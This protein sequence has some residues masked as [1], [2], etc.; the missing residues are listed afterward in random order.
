MK[1]FFDEDGWQLVMF[2]TKTGI[3]NEQPLTINLDARTISVPSAVATCA[4]VQKDQLAEML[5]FEVDRFFDIMD[6][7]NTEIF[8]QWKTTDREGDTKIAIIDF[9]TRAGKLLFAWPLTDDITSASGAVKFSARFLVK[10]NAGAIIYSLNTQEATLNI[11]PALAANLNS[12]KIDPVNAGMFEHIVFNSQNAAAGKSAPH[13]PHFNDLDGNIALLST[14]EDGD[15][16][17]VPLNKVDSKLVA[18]LVN[19]TVSFCARAYTTDLGDIRYK[20]YYVHEDAEGVEIATPYSMDD[21]NNIRVQELPVL[22]PAARLEVEGKTPNSNFRYYKMVKDPNSELMVPAPCTASDFPIAEGVKLY[23]MYSVFT[24]PQQDADPL[25]DDTVVGK[26]YVA[27]INYKN[28]LST[29]DTPVRSHECILPGPSDIQIES[30]LGTSKIVDKVETVVDEETG[31]IR[32]DVADDEAFT[33]VLS[34]NI[35]NADIVYNWMVKTAID[36]EYAPVKKLVAKFGENGEPEYDAEGEPIFEEVIASTGAVLE[37]DKLGWYKA[38]IVSTLNRKDT[39]VYSDE[40]KVT[41]EPVAP[42]VTLDGSQEMFELK[43]G[44]TKELKINATVPNANNP[45][46][47]EGLE[48]VWEY[49]SVTNPTP[50]VVTEEMSDIAEVHDNVLIAKYV[51]NQ[52]QFGNFTCTVYNHLNERVA[53]GTLPVGDSYTI[54]YI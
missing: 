38:Q 53:I 20:W 31:E 47:S 10:N 16:V 6:L 34:E 27:A 3:A 21:E 7:S 22:V 18:N 48:Y 44:E 4:G 1:H 41:F 5:I 28:D 37:I 46:Y 19:D 36:G 39:D 50:V 23:E 40:C 11:K 54:K 8:I 42:T 25:T 24:I 43:T 9:A 13:Q 49:S 14:N 15:Y 45:L 29:E 35:Y 12:F 17:A 52:G 51:N 30:N 32:I 33:I 2:A 26:Y